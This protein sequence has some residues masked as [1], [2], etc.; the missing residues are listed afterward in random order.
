M[1]NDYKHDGIGHYRIDRMDDVQI[2]ENPMTKIEET[3]GYDLS[4][5]KRALFGMFNGEDARDNTIQETAYSLA[6]RQ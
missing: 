4:R 1:C 3:K 5:H 2:T 6:H